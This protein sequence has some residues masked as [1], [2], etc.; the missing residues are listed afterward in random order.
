M[1]QSADASRVLQVFGVKLLGFSP[2]NARKFVLSVLLVAA[3]VLTGRV[4]KAIARRGARDAK[5]ER[6][7]FWTHQGISIAVAVLS[8]VG[9]VSIWFDNPS[10]LSTAFGLITAGL[11]F[12]LQRVVTALAGYI[13]I[14]RGKTFNV[15]DR[16]TMGGIRGDVIALGF[17]QTTIMEMGQPPSVQNADPAMWVQSRQYSGRIVTV[18]NAKIFDDPVYN[19]T[20]DFPYIWEELHLP[21]QYSADR[22]RAE[23]ILL[24]AAR[25]NTIRIADLSEPALKELER[26]YAIKS[27]ELEPTVYLRLTDNWIEMAVRF[28]VEDYGVREVKSQMSREI[29]DGFEQAGIGIASGTYDIVGLPTVKVQVIPPPGP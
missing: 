14:L 17:L 13:V 12:A 2:E 29:L 20:R 9:L 11:A 23:A 1:L 16:I 10:R 6:V 15:G 19:Y 24:E 21:I 8:L 28:I 22:K 7:A 3:V 18:T 25:R 4:L 26:R 27:A 5:S